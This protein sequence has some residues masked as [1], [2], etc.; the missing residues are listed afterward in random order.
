MC[1]LAN[2]KLINFKIFKFNKLKWENFILI[3]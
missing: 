3:N 2:L 1:I